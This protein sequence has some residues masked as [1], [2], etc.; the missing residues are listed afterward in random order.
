M[1]CFRQNEGLEEETERKGCREGAEKE[2]REPNLG[3]KC[4]SLLVQAPCRTQEKEV[5]KELLCEQCCRVAEGF[6]RTYPRYYLSQQRVKYI[7]K[8]KENTTLYSVSPA[9]KLSQT[10]E[11]VLAFHGSKSLE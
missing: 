2:C 10:A 3:L 8:V 9:S 7:S 4:V 11:R 5:G 6:V 1:R